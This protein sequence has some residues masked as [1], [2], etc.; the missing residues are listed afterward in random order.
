MKTNEFEQNYY[1]IT[2]IFLK[3]SHLDS[4]T[5]NDV[6]PEMLSGVQTGNRNLTELDTAQP[7]LLFFEIVTKTGDFRKNLQIWLFLI[8]KSKF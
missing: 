1:N 6:K 3:T 5:T 2:W 7:Q 4:N 8:K